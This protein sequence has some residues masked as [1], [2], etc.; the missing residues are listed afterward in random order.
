MDHEP[1]LDLYSKLEV[2]SFYHHLLVKPYDY[3]AACLLKIFLRKVSLDFSAFLHDDRFNN[4]QKLA[5]LDFSE[6]PLLV[7]LLSKNS[8]NGPAA[9]WSSQV[10]FLFTGY[11]IV[12]A[13]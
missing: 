7:S 12:I 5:Q 9:F 11:E 4:H 2:L 10:N 13:S 1:F 8:Q 3:L 6:D